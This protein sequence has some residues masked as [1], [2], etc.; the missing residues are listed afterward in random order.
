MGCV[1]SK[2]AESEPSRTQTAQP[3]KASDQSTTTVVKSVTQSNGS[4]APSSVTL[5]T[6]EGGL[7][8]QTSNVSKLSAAT[9]NQDVQRACFG[10]GCYWGTEKFFRYDCAKKNNH[11]GTLI[12]GKVGFMGPPSAPVNPTYKD[13]CSGTTGH[14]EV[15]EIEFT[16]G[17]A[18]YEALVR[19]FFQFHD[20]TT[21]NKQGNDRG[22]QYASVIYC[23]NEEQVAIATRVKEELQALLDSGRL[24]AKVFS[25][26][27]IATDIRQ[28][29]TF[30]PA[31]E[32]HQDYL[33]VNPHGYCNHRIRF[34]EW[35]SSN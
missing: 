28:A 16:G 1:S 26:G 22:T 10:A 33:N 17:A 29:T 20:P 14:V 18:Y 30:Y 15:Y 4:T 9:S 24:G 11:L 25:N 7:S 21:M 31:H 5:G 6:A 12:S 32:E 34:K 23:Y 35:P 19:F 27:W 2:A 8:T 13:V 3:G